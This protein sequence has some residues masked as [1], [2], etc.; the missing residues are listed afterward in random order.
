MRHVTRR[1]GLAGV[2]RTGY[3]ALRRSIKGAPLAK[4]IAFFNNKGG[5][6]KTTTCFNLGWMLAERGHRVI[7][8]DAD[9][10]CNLT[11]MVLDLSQSDSLSRFYKNNPGRNLRDALE[12]AFKSRPIPLKPVNCI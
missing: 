10:Q 5:V 2:L 11:G 6:S 8:V 4:T 1:R 12:P 7:M 9:P 3:A